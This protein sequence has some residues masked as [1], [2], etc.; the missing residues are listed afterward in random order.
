MTKPLNVIFICQLLLL[1]Y[2]ALLIFLR[3][4]FVSR[5]HISFLSLY[6]KTAF[7][8]SNHIAL[9]LSKLLFWRYNSKA[10]AKRYANFYPRPKIVEGHQK[11]SNKWTKPLYQDF[12]QI[13]RLSLTL[14]Q[15]ANGKNETFAICLQPFEQQSE[16]ILS[17]VTFFYFYVI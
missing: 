2:L 1:N 9:Y 15:T 16:S 6:Q 17:V 7:L 3:T 5:Y 11:L 4:S 13:E 10:T 12:L 8:V 14:R